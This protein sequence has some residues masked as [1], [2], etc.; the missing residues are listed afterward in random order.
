[1]QPV[2]HLLGRD[3]SPASLDL[4]PLVLRAEELHGRLSPQGVLDHERRVQEPRGQLAQPGAPAV[5]HELEVHN[6]RQGVCGGQPAVHSA[7]QGVAVSAQV[8]SK[9]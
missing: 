9:G 3:N 4:V 7:G 8:A 6:V 1:M 2:P 5:V